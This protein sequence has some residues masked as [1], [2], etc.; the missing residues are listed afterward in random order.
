PRAT[1]RTATS[2]GRQGDIILSGAAD[3]SSPLA[4][5]RCPLSTVSGGDLLNVRTV[6]N[7]EGG[8]EKDTPVSVEG[9]LR[10]VRTCLV[11]HIS[12]GLG[13]TIPK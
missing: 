4:E 3:P 6:N 10:T 2:S 12:T 5:T 7:K 9:A 8:S 1:R 11:R 13:L